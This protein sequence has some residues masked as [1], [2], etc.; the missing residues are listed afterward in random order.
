MKFFIRNGQDIRID[1]FYITLFPIT[2]NDYG[3]RTLFDAVLFKNDS[4]YEELGRVKIGYLGELKGEEYERI[5]IQTY[6][7]ESFECLDDAFCSLWQETDSY[8]KIRDME[9][10]YSIEILKP[11]NDIILMNDELID[12][13][14][15]NEFV[16]TSLMR[17]VSPIM[18]KEEFRNAYYGDN[19]DFFTFKHRYDDANE[20]STSV[21]PFKV[22][23][24]DCP[25]TNV[26]AI[27][28]PN[29]CG[30][31]YTITKIIER[32]K[33][34]DIDYK[35]IESII[36]VSFNP[37]DDYKQFWDTSV[38]G[39]GKYKKRF[40]FIGSKTIRNQ[41]KNKSVD[42]LSDDFVESLYGCL[43][44]ESKTR[45]WSEFL[46]EMIDS[47][48]IPMLEKLLKIQVMPE[49]ES[50]RE[51]C[52]VI[53]NKLSA[54]YKEVVSIVTGTICRMNEKSLI[55][56]DEPENHLHPPLLSM[57]IRW[58]SKI[59]VKR[60]AFAIIATHSPI[61][62]QEIP[63]SC[64]W[65]MERFGEVRK[66]R[67]PSIETFG[68][69]LSILTY[70]AFKYELPN[71]GFHKLLEDAAHKYKNYDSALGSFNSQLGEEARAILRLLCYNEVHNNEKNN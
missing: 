33:E 67:R 12:T 34:N 26:H 25:P 69:N 66:I 22:V 64:V 14:M 9:H 51:G 50:S 21:I 47:F 70:E 24:N 40:V 62:V 45:E 71:T 23:R 16:N 58:L 44:S 38:F 17:F 59:L 28:G 36:L 39:D 2:W 13:I 43:A 7:P 52:K 55:L 49:C 19:E 65:I 10:K 11:I 31:T 30:K 61:V 41:G 48:N 29:A 20:F 27:I 37:F 57:L 32:F 53:F 4:I 60:N 46:E 8:I 1:G 15:K 35:F 6:L 5:D 56:L 68:T 42:E 54:G 18:C 63:K 3:Y